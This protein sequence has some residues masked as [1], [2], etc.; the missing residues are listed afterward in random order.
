MIICLWSAN[1]P[2]FHNEEWKEGKELSPLMKV[3]ISNRANLSNLLLFI[4]IYFMFRACKISN[5]RQMRTRPKIWPKITKRMETLILSAKSTGRKVKISVRIN[6]TV[7]KYEI[8]ISS[9]C[10]VRNCQLHW[11]VESWWIWCDS[12]H[13]ALHKQ[14]RCTVPYWKL[15]VK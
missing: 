6:F 2:F 7:V 13:T 1:H 10:K 3:Q 12:E 8:C 4:L 5:T 14:G 15:Q 9:L 11:R